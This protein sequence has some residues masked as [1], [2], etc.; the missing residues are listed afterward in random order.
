MKKSIL[1]VLIAGLL[2]T[3]SC[4]K[5]P[6]AC[7]DAPTTGTVNQPIKFTSCSMDTDNVEWNF[8]DGSKSTETS[9]THTYTSVG[10]YTVKCMAMSKNKKKMDEKST[11]IT[12]Q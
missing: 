10:T 1:L 3:M 6:M 7:I 11:T 5:K 12:I 4:M 8:G 2:T 9:P